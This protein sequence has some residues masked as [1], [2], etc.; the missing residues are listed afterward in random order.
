VSPAELYECGWGGKESD[1]LLGARLWVPGPLK[2][3]GFVPWHL[4]GTNRVGGAQAQGVRE[5]A[6]QMVGYASAEESVETE[7][8]LRVRLSGSRY[9][10]DQV[11]PEGREAAAVGRAIRERLRSPSSAGHRGK[12]GFALSKESS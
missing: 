6:F 1:A 8:G 12:T 3:D 4:R 9:V 7:E 10:G 11:S 5:R 2:S